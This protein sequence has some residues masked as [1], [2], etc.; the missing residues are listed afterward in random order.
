MRFQIYISAIEG[1]VPADMV[2]AFRAFGEFCYIARCDVHN[3]TTLQELD[4]AL[5][6]FHQ[7]RQIFVTTGVR[8]DFSL[9][10]QHSLVHYYALIRLFG[11]PNGLCSSIT[12]SKHIKA[13][14]E[15][16]RRSSRYQALGQ[17]LL[18]NQRL[19]KLAAC[20]VDFTARGML[21][22]LCLTNTLAS[23]AENDNDSDR[24]SDD[25]ADDHIS[26]DNA[27]DHISDDNADDHIS[28]DNN[29]NFSDDNEDN[30]RG[31]NNQAPANG[32]APIPHGDPSMAADDGDGAVDGP[33]IDSYV[34]LAQTVGE[35]FP[36]W[37]GLLLIETR[38]STLGFYHC[39]RDPAT[40]TSISHPSVS[41]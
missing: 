38:P 32:A 30:I 33:T 11:A 37:C 17:M 13:V 7:Y 19:D 6:R 1:H 15:P 35:F 31:N 8:T 24:I 20:R 22:G 16:W 41:I 40:Q 29:D 18:T 3:E 5:N 2:R 27:D 12:E 39:R 9:P 10:R 21:H 4:D 26:D 25:N 14:K 36:P 23:M 34:D 28:N